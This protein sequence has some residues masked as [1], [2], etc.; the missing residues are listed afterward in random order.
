LTATAFRAIVGARLRAERRAIGFACAIAAVAA[1]IQPHGIATITDPL[2]ADVTIRSVWLAGPMF[3]C[4]T[5]GIALALIQG[6]GRNTHLDLSERSAPLFGRELARAKAAAPVITATLATLVYWS[7]Q[8]LTG[9][10]AP[11]TFFVLAL[12]SVIAATLVA[13]N[14]TIRTGTARSA[15]IS[16]AAAT[17]VAC[18]LISL[19]ADPM[20]RAR[21]DVIGVTIELL[22]CAIVS[23]F[24]LR[25][26][27]EA[28]ARYDPLQ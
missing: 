9:F 16:L 13:I 1:F 22:F 28:L 17:V 27:G 15:A 20:T 8:Y 23:Y 19:Y 4:G 26:Y 7:A 2:D 3:V 5:I 10:A 18:Y 24:A 21:S 25:E 6:P 14:A 11:P 12:A